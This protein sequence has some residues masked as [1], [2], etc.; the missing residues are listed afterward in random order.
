MKGDDWYL[1]ELE[2]VQ[3]EERERRTAT[4]RPRVDWRALYAFALGVLA[5]WIVW[6]HM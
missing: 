2:R 4:V 1:A 6:G 3:R 5:G